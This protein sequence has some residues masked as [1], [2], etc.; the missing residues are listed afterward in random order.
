MGPELLP[1]SLSSIAG[2][3]GE[4]DC[5]SVVFQE[6]DQ[7]VFDWKKNS[8]FSLINDPDWAPSAKVLGE[9]VAEAIE[10]GHCGTNEAQK[11]FDREFWHHVLSILHWQYEARYG[12]G[13]KAVAKKLSERLLGKIGMMVSLARDAKQWIGGGVVN[14]QKDEIGRGITLDSLLSPS[15]KYHADFMAVYRIITNSVPEKI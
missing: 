11:I 5:L 1:C 7:Q 9:V 13:Q 2:K 6:N 12:E 14:R 15:S 4:V 8:I 3:I 10:E